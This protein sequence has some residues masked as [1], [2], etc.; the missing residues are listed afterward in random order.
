MSQSPFRVTQSVLEQGDPRLQR[1]EIR[2][3]R[4][5]SFSFKTLITITA[6]VVIL[7]LE[8]EEDEKYRFIFRETKT[9]IIEQLHLYK[10]GKLML[11][12]L[13]Q[14]IIRDTN[15]IVM[16]YDP[17]SEE[18]DVEDNCLRYQYYPRYDVEA[19][20]LP[21]LAC[22]LVLDRC[23]LCLGLVNLEDN[24]LFSLA[25]FTDITI[26]RLGWFLHDADEDPEESV[27]SFY[28]EIVPRLQ[29]KYPTLTYF[30]REEIE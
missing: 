26:I 2:S 10:S 16:R 20:V 6:P 23:N 17:Q 9:L 27:A 18:E 30:P 1:E 7:D 21:R 14:L 8:D 4:C 24:L 19:I 15:I 3:I 11:S 28:N 29:A 13:E 12:P 5:G 25:Y 22:A